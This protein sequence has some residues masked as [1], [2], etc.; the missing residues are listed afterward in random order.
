MAVELLEAD[1]WTLNADGTPYS[2]TGTRYKEVT[3]EEAGTY[4]LNVTLADGRILMPLHIKWSS[5]EGNPVSELLAVMLANGTQVADAG[6]VIEQVTMTFDELLLYMYRDGT[7]GE[8][9]A[10]PT[11]GMYN[12]GSNFPAGY[13]YAYSFTLDPDL[14]AQGRNLNYILDEKLDKLS[15]DMVYGVESGDDETYLDLWQQFM[16]RWNE[17]L[18]DIPLYSNIYLTITP[19]W[20]QGYE[21]SSLWGFDQ[22]IVYCSIAGAE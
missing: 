9:Y 4:E 17:L 3:P 22:A 21:E 18:P 6:M 15:M 5:S 11:Y 1:G 2:G 20:L 12:M 13:A 8:R 16:V 14:L 7:Q 19:D 10:V